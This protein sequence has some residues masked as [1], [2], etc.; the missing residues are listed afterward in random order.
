MAERRKY[1]KRA[2][3]FVIAV[4]LDL[5]TDGFTYRKWDDVQTCK[6]GDW[7]VDNEGDVYTV[8]AETFRRTYREVERGRWVK[9]APV[10]AEVAE[11]D[12]K[13][14]TKEG[15]THY[16]AGDYIVFNEPDGGDGYAVTA[17][18]FRSMYEPAP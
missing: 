14:R 2:D 10:W 4:R 1:R 6:P 17:E 18:K 8:D 3:A 9:A 7:I 13:I 12:G 5:D 11:T 16:R 15:A